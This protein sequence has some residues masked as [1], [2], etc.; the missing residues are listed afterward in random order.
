MVRVRNRYA[1]NVLVIVESPRQD[2]SQNRQLETW[3]INHNAKFSSARPWTHF[4]WRLAPCWISCHPG[5][6]NDNALFF[7]H[8]SRVFAISNSKILY[9][10]M[11]F[12]NRETEKKGLLVSPKVVLQLIF[13]GACCVTLLSWYRRNTWLP[14]T[15]NSTYS[16]II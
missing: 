9:S 6:T 13:I 14:K 1:A 16:I 2:H 11:P 3:I 7:F 15:I 12:R 5:R 10:E 4:N 8:L